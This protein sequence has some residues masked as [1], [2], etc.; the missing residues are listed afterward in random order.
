MTKQTH[1]WVLGVDGTWSQREL[2]DMERKAVEDGWVFG[3]DITYPLI[4][5]TETELKEAL[6]IT[7]DTKSDIG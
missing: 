1:V 7:L 5:L 3:P 6:K 2:T 4:T